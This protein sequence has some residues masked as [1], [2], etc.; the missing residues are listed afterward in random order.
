M[1]NVLLA[2]AAILAFDAVA[3]SQ[4]AVKKRPIQFDE[5]NER[6][7]IGKLGV[8]LGTAIDIQ[9]QIVSGEAL[10]RKEHAV[11]YLLKVTH[12]AGA[13]LEKAPLLKF[14]VYGAGGAKIASNQF[15][16][17]ELKKGKKTGRLDSVQIKELEKGYVGKTVRLLVCEYGSFNG[18]PNNLPKDFPSWAEPEF[19][20]STSLFVLGEKK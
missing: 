16:L 14:G 12:V 1:K 9:A 20:F 18:V 5:L 17:F 3:Y 19:Y 4:E 2:V 13:K 7:V 6:P 11:D 15:D 8:P 10:R